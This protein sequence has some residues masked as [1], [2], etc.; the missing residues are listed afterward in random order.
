MNRK[1]YRWAFLLTCALV[2]GC[3]SSGVTVQPVQQQAVTPEWMSSTEMQLRE[4]IKN[5]SFTL[6]RL[7][8]GWVVT[9]PAQQSFNPD[10]P[11]LLMPVVLGPITR[12]AKIM[13]SRPDSAVL[14]LGHTDQFNDHKAS[15]KLSSDRARA[16]ASIFRLSGLGNGRMKHLGMGSAYTLSA[17]QG[18]TQNHRVEIIVIPRSHM[19]DVVAEYQPAYNRQLAL[20]EAR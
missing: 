18:S 8:Q 13:E 11:D 16:V 17:L 12:I 6:N 14:I 20:T 7:E 3:S 4:S 19:H 9:A 5:S 2:A 15:Y 1:L 10:R